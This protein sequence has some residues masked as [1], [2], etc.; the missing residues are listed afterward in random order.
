MSRIGK[1][2]AV[3]EVDSRQLANVP[4][5]PSNDFVDEI[6]MNPSAPPRPLWMDRNKLSP[7][8]RDSFT[9]NTDTDT[10]DENWC[11]KNEIAGAVI[12]RRGSG[13]YT[14]WSIVVRTV[15]R[16][17]EQRIRQTITLINR[18]RIN[19]IPSDIQ[20]WEEQHGNFRIRCSSRR[21]KR[22]SR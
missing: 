4:M 9:K 22:R 20:R 13:S 8:K 10:V 19:K 15:I 1:W 3:H 6:D 17:E 16:W 2:S 14:G 11:L 18:P 12:N 5:K 21:N 7:E